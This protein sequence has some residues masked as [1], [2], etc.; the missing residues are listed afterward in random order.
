MPTPP[1][2]PEEAYLAAERR[3]SQPSEYVNGEVLP[4]PAMSEAHAMLAGNI[5]TS[6]AQQL[7]GRPWKVQGS[8]R[9]LYVPDG[10]LYT[11]PDAA[12]VC[13]EAEFW[14]D[15]HHD[16]LLNPSLLVKVLPHAMPAHFAQVFESYYRIPTVQHV[17]LVTEYAA[18]VSLGS[19]NENGL[20][21]VYG[22]TGLDDVIL[23]PDLGMELPLAEIYQNVALRA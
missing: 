5:C 7:N 17:L 10:P 18:R 15:G 14:P 23:L 20:L 21:N 1:S 6:L 16:N 22:F 8:H 3:A 4:M 2:S 12:L 13:G 11:Y 19:R 9:R